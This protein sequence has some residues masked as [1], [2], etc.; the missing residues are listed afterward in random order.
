MKSLRGNKGA[1]LNLTCHWIRPCSQLWV[2][3]GMLE[4]VAQATPKA[5]PRAT[6]KATAKATLK[7]T[8]RAKTKAKKKAKVAVPKT[9]L[10]RRMVE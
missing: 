1:A 4:V 9:P 2:P 6:L 5:T 8:P 10:K 3:Y 7:A